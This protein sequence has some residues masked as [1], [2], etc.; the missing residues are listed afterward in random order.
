MKNPFAKTGTTIPT[1]PPLN[2]VEVQSAPAAEA[3]IAP[4]TPEPNPTPD[5]PPAEPPPKPAPVS[6]FKDVPCGYPPT[7]GRIVHVKV[8]DKNG[9]RKTLPAI[10]TGLGDG[11]PTINA[12]VFSDGT[13]EHDAKVYTGLTYRTPSEDPEQDESNTW[14]WPPRV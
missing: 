1:D 12:A 5:A 13:L 3:T 7:I 8:N 10:V 11:V 4:A 14:H 6:A 2:T 9:K